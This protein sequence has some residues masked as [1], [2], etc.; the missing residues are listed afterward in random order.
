MPPIL[1]GWGKGEGEGEEC[2][3][4]CCDGR[5]ASVPWVSVFS[6]RDRRR[7]WTAGT[8]ILAINFDTPP[9]T[10]LVV[11]DPV[12]SLFFRSRVSAP[13][14]PPSF[15]P[16]SFSAQMQTFTWRIQHRFARVLRFNHNAIGQH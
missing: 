4:S 12:R 11:L 9:L 15:P 6:V 2:D 3:T 14:L 7:G 1:L 5:R 16:P 13:S 8:G 10:S